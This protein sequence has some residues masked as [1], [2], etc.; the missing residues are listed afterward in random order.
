M[1][2]GSPASAQKGNLVL[3][4]CDDASIGAGPGGCDA[5]LKSLTN[6]ISDFGLTI[7]PQSGVPEAGPTDE[8]VPASVAARTKQTGA[9]FS[10][11]FSRPKPTPR[12]LLT[13]HIYDPGIEQT[14]S[15]TI[16]AF[17]ASGML[18]HMD[19][20]FH[21]R[22]IMGA[23]LYSDITEIANDAN[24]VALAVPE[25]HLEVIESH[26][27]ERRTWVRLDFGYLVLGFPTENHW[28]HG[29][30]FDAAVLPIPRLE[31]FV[32]VGIT[33]LQDPV[34]TSSPLWTHLTNRQILLGVG[35]RYDLLGHDRIA[36]LPE[37][38]F[39]VGISSTDV[40]VETDLH[41]RTVHPA[42]W[43][44]LELRVR[45]TGRFSFALGLRFENLFKRERVFLV[46][47]SGEKTM[48]FRAS[49]FRFGAVGALC[50]SI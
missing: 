27:P 43:A 12:N 6:E 11:W 1:L 24:L 46:E 13:L 29:F 9:I 17:D 4:Y 39:H 16:P 41:Y 3:F 26:K 23:S 34:T 40:T 49:Q 19:V 42:V 28:Y 7:E 33:F 21:T 37:A 18:N 45:V 14:I 25:E 50:V 20:S 30:M 36:L 48:I 47:E 5:L 44:G 35:A 38:G 22:I 8:H 31:A 10:V 32:D 2:L 15:R